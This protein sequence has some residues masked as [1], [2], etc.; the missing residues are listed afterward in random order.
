MA[1][2][3]PAAPVPLRSSSS[4]GTREG[5]A[6]P[7]RSPL[8][9]AILCALTL[10]GGCSSSFQAG[11]PPP[12]DRLASLKAGISTREDVASALGAPQGN[13]AAALA[14]KGS[15]QD[16]LVYQYLET[17]GQQI[18]TRTLLVLIDKP[19]GLYQGYWWFRSGQVVGINQ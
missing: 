4:P 19:T 7:R 11:N 10:L 5:A 9:G 16:V 18:R 14:T 1:I 12:V 15:A 13:G 17:N 2:S 6:S 8:L 3:G